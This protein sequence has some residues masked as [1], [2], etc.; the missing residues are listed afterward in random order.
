M[1]MGRKS[2]REQNV[3][4]ENSP[5]VIIIRMSKGTKKKDAQE[6]GPIE[7]IAVKYSKNNFEIINS[8]FHY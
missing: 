8:F 5:E 7:H 6:L 2:Q 4:G 3:K 1:A